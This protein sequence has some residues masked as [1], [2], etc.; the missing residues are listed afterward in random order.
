MFTNIEITTRCNF[1]CFYCAGRAMAQSDMEWSAFTGIADTIA[2]GSTV[3]LGGE[4]EPTL[5]PRFWE[6]AEYLKSKKCIPTL[7][8]NASRVNAEK[9]DANFRRF[10]ISLD[11][12]DE[13]VAARLGRH[14]LKKVLRNIEE[15]LAVIHPRR[16]QILTVDFGQ[17]LDALKEKV[18]TLKMRHFI[19]KVQQK[20]DYG[21]MAGYAP[22]RFFR[23]NRPSVCSHLEFDVRRFHTI[24]G[25]VLPCC[26]M[27]DTTGFTTIEKARS[28]LLAGDILPGCV[29]CVNL[30]DR[31]K[32]KPMMDY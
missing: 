4:G 23:P 24:D 14:N 1:D 18:K 7:I 31:P 12:L 29:G 9:F 16:I 11:T 20:E 8:T 13:V 17:P 5:H 28:Q 15:L 10:S 26:M 3:C 25:L 2:P 6:M 21:R 22:V 30:K 27:K 32:S 19:Q